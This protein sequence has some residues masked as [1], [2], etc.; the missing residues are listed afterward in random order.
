MLDWEKISAV[1]NFR[2]G[3]LQE[4]L[5][6]LGIFPLQ[7]SCMMSAVNHH[8]CSGPTILMKNFLFQKYSLLIFL[9]NIPS[10]SVTHY[11]HFISN[12]ESLHCWYRILILPLI[13]LDLLYF[14]LILLLSIY[15]TLLYIILWPWRETSSISYPFLE[16]WFDL[17]IFIVTY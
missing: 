13:L 10:S 16:S 15:A 5:K 9:M 6:Q 8:H 4:C 14:T 7:L 1:C 12:T 11:H 3:C 17:K 2:G